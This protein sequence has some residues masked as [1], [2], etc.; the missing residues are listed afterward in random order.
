VPRIYK[1]KGD[2]R[3]CE[4]LTALFTKDEKQRIREA[5]SSRNLPVSIFIHQAVIER[6]GQPT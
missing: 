2:L 1:T 4:Y 3:R 5:A 6:I